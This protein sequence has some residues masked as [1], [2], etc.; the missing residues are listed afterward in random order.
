MN[1]WIGRDLEKRYRKDTEK[2]WI[3]ALEEK[4]CRIL[5]GSADQDGEKKD[6]ML[7][8]T[9][10]KT[11]LERAKKH[12]FPCIYLETEKEEAFVYGAELAA[13]EAED[14]TQELCGSVYR[15]FYE[16]PS[17][18][19]ETPRLILRECVPQDTQALYRIYEGETCLDPLPEDPEEEKQ[20][21]SAYFQNM[22][23]F[24]GYGIWSVI[25]K[26]SGQLIGRA[27]IENG[28]AGQRDILEMG[29]LIGKPWR[30]KGY[31]FEAAGAVIRWAQERTDEEKLYLK[32]KRE[33][34]ASL[35]LAEKLG[36]EKISDGSVCVFCKK[37]REEE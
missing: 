14:L 29:Y 18:I 25:E 8:I 7:C 22:Y 1:I 2:N 34:T 6:R 19:A 20:I 23:G 37:I 10:L 35:H 15:R 28:E 21:L 4:G 31:A 33:N 13:E 17:V 27:G 5:W 30:R 9:N 26:Q 24:Y 36:F 16:I 3:G 12:G 11:E 32:I